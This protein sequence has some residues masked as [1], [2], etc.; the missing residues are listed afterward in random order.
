LNTFT[1]ALVWL[2]LLPSAAYSQT[3]LVIVS[4]LGGDPRYT[5]QFT[6][7]ASK[8]ADSARTRFGIPAENIS[9]LGEQQSARSPLYRG[10]ATSDAIHGLLRSLAQNV[11]AREQLVIVLIGHGG[12]EGDNTRIS[13]PGPD[14]TVADFAK[15]LERFP[16]Q[17]V[18]FVNLTSA[19]GDGMK[20]LSGERRVVITATKSS[21]ERNESQFGRYFITALT[22]PVA[23]ADKDE[24]VSLLEAFN[25]AATETKRFY[26]N[27]GR[28]ATEHPQLDDST[29]ARR[30]FLDAGRSVAKASS[31]PQLA[32]LYRSQEEL[33]ARIDSLRSRRSGMPAAAYESQLEKLLTEFAER[34]REIRQREAKP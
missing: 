5:A 10:R 24:R 12:G 26:E 29:R 25:Y 15:M 14:M 1:R 31:D 9:W 30:L 20:T 7:L 8:L 23:D 6:S 4:G 32:G 11:G 13:L 16:T 22:T 18:A 19:S 27:E 33:R 28:L 34:A 17:T 21:F 2:L 3:H